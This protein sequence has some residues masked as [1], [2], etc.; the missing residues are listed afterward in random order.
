[1][2]R[3][4]SSLLQSGVLILLYFADGSLAS[5]IMPS[6]PTKDDLV[7]FMQ[8]GI[9]MKTKRKAIILFKSEAEQ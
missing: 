3:V 6:A 9:S 5:L 8:R 1:M 4:V 7:T 2:R